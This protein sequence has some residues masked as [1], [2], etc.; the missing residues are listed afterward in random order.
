[1]GGAT[2][3]PPPPPLV[4]ND[5]FGNRIVLSGLPVS[6]TGS[7]IGA[8]AEPQEPSQSGP[9]NSV[10]WSWTAPNTETVNINTRGSNFD[11][12]LSVF[13]GSNL[14]NLTLIGANDDAGGSLTSL[15]SLNATAGTTYQIAVDGY[16]SATGAIGLNIVV[17]PPP[18][19]NFANQIA[20]TGETATTTGSNRGATSE[21]GEPNQSG[22]TNS[23]WW[24]WTAPTTGI[25]NIDTRGSNFDT[26]LSV[27]TGSAVNNLTLIDAN[28]DG[29][30]NLASLVS[31]N[32]TAGTT[33]RIAV[34]GYSS[35]TGAV[36]LNIAP[37]PPA[38]DNFANRIALTGSRANATGSNRG[39]TSEV[40]EPAQ[41]GVTNSVWWTWRAPTTGIYTFDTI[42]SRFDTYL[43]LFT[44]TNLPSLT[45]VAADDDGGGNLTSRIT[46]IVTA[47]TTY[48]IA[49][50]GYS[51]AT[52]PINLNIARTL[53]FPFPFAGADNLTETADNTL[54]GEADEDILTGGTDADTLMLPF[55]ESSVSASVPG[56]DFAASEKIDPL[57]QGGV[58]LNA[59]SLFSP[60]ADSAVPTLVKDLSPVFTEANGAS[61]VGTQPLAVNSEPFG[62]AKT[63][64]FAD[65]YLGG[66]YEPKQLGI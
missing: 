59:P 64:P 44:G 23:A 42:G 8:T 24:S 11:T 60:A 65:P 17:P 39:A 30:G 2:P 55:A 6:T 34:D 3:P 47:G 43:S 16:S 1:L 21:V 50:D 22:I 7:N 51:S 33:Y 54:N 36:Q 14:P 46:R 10:W 31:L 62:V 61:L 58:A 52:G 27:F 29:G 57:T 45:R 28:D 12:Y 4:P 18:N 35:A 40:G 13:T 56:S 49:V 38:N 26:Y 15:V 53:R 41:S 37:P 25:Y 32:A 20:L 48:Q 5:N 19:D 66:I 63:S 9:I